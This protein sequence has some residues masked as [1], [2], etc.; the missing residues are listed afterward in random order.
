MN[1]K[2]ILIVGAIVGVGYYLY[3]KSKKTTVLTGA[4]GVDAY[5]L[6]AYEEA[7]K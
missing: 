5:T 3:T 4:S 1:L 7:N 2:T 6:N